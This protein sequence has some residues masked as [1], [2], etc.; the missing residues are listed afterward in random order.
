MDL[1]Q[2]SVQPI[3]LAFPLRHGERGAFATNDTTI[4]AINDDLKI[5]LNTNHGERVIQYDFGANLRAILFESGP[6]V[7]QQIADNIAVAIEKWLPSLTLENLEV[8]TNDDNL[9]I[10][11]NSVQVNIQYNVGNTGLRG[12]VTITVG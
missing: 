2:P 8:E 12:D 10:N 6:D 9:S 4:D 3:N 7:K 5:L 1:K 11:E